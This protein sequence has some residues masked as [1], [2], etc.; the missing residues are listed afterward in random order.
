MRRIQSACLQQTIHF[1]LKDQMAQPAAARLAREEYESFQRQLKEN[2]VQ[3]RITHEEVLPD[4]S[5]LIRILRQYNQYS[6]GDYL[7]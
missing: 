3:Y 7:G 6:C 2:R 4:G 5:I 1:P